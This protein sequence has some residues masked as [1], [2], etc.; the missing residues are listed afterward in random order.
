MYS[1]FKRF[2]VGCTLYRA[3]LG[4]CPVWGR[5]AVEAKIGLI[6]SIFLLKML[7]RIFHFLQKSFILYSKGEKER[8]FI[9]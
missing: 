9:I 6:A 5:L 2:Y 3:K 8:K 1:L 7:Y 4:T